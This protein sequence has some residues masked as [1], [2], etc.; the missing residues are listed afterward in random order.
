MPTEFLAQNGAKINQ[1]TPIGVS[2]CKPKLGIV[3]HSV[4]GTKATIVVS[5]PSAGRLLATGKGVSTGRGMAA[6]A[7]DVRVQVTLTRAE[8]A[9][10]RKHK[11]RKLRAKIT[12]RFTPK[13]GAKLTTSVTVLIA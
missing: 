4:K 11:S 1:S 6:K 9:F 2:G 12:L 7:G 3:R 10:L 5:V 13:K 8:Q